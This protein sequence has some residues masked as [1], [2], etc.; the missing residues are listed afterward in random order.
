MIRLLVTSEHRLNAG[1]T[2]A[3]PDLSAFYGGVLRQPFT[4]AFSTN[5]PEARD[6]SPP[7]FETRVALGLCFNHHFFSGA[8]TVDR[9]APEEHARKLVI[10]P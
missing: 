2:P 7:D 9:E 3:L 6:C 10:G 1:P 5:T 8:L 4:V